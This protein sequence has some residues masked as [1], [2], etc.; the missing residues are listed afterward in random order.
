[1]PAI[2]QRVLR[3]LR[4]YKNRAVG[5]VRPPLR[6]AVVGAG[7]IAPDHVAGYEAG[8]AARVV[9]VSD[10]RPAALAKALDRWPSVRAYRDYARMLREAKP[11]L[12]SVCTW[13]QSHAEIV[14]RA[15]A[16]G[17]KGIL[18]EKPMALRLADMDAMIAACQEHGVKLAVGH[19][20]R[21]HPHFVW[22]AGV[23]RDN[24]L[25]ELRGVRG[26]ITST[27]ANN[28]PH[29]FDTVRFVLGDPAAREVA[30]AVTRD[31][32]GYNRAV[33]AEESASGH[34]LFET[35]VRF[36]FRTGELAPTFFAVVLEGAN[37]E[38][39]ITPAGVEVRGAA[40]VR[41]P[42][43]GGGDPRARQFGEFIAWV[44]GQQPA[45]AA[46][47]E[48]SRRTGELVLAAYEA[49]RTK[50]AVKLPLA[51]RG[52]VLGWMDGGPGA[53]APADAPEYVPPLPPADGRGD[54]LAMD[55]GRR[56]ARKWFSL[57]PA[58]GTAE[59][60]GL[61]RVVLSKQLNCVEGTV[62]KALEREFAALY[63]APKAVASTS[64]TSAV[65]VALGALGL[66]PG[67]EVVT[68]PLTDMGTVI[69]ILASN[70]IPVFADIDPVTGNLSAETIAQKLTPRTKAVVVVHLFGRPADLGPIAELLA[71]RGIPLVEDCAQAHLAEYRGK[72][73]GTFGAFGCF[74]LQ[75]SKQITCGDGGLTLVNR[76]EHAERAALF[77]DKGWDR[78]K[79][80]RSHLFLGMNYRMTELQGAVAR[81]QVARVGKLIAARRAAADRLTDL[82]KGVPGVEPVPTPAD[83]SPSWWMYQ[84]R[85][86]EEAVGLSTRA[87]AEVLR[88]E[89]VRALA[90]YVPEPVFNYP[91][92]REPRTFGDSGFPFPPG[93]AQPR[94]DDYPGFR[95]FNDRLL[96]L[97]W[98]HNVRG[99]HVRGIAEAARKVAAY[100]GAARAVRP[101]PVPVG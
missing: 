94:A 27:L 96:F 33:P 35:G 16:A 38:V 62:V 1:M 2:T 44:K 76:P 66:N 50:A 34:V 3:R 48:S 32:G 15:A 41:P 11:D 90:D 60:T 29:L 23:V 73:V 45:Y 98:S 46:D 67:D 75:Q 25:G 74:S 40:G 79:G 26:H 14:A 88:A 21:F 59:I 69:P 5:A 28:G 24:L 43:A 18:C 17:A 77:V 37:G 58:M 64:G 61:T 70:C 20:Y 39:E 36:E 101:E 49:A 53:D 83:V 95:A 89:G 57:K 97:Q 100:A 4:K 19:Q 12:V 86:D 80:L 10:L 13:P 9:A 51:V 52:D 55:G 54:R 63:G 71:A 47:A 30:C 85:V 78:K 81:A 91:V 72:K 84:M 93:Y 7:E 22:A 82:L 99:G 65:H 68:T 8:P 92:L 87:F 31:Q 6:V 56:A 42:A